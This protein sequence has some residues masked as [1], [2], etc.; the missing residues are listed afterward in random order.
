MIV[1]MIKMDFLHKSSVG[2]RTDRTLVEKVHFNHF[3]LRP[4]DLC[5]LCSKYSCY[6]GGPSK[7]AA[8]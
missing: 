6:V 1:K 7:P 4:F 3:Y 5:S 2:S 8:W